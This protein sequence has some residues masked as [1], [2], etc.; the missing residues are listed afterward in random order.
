MVFRKLVFK[1]LQEIE[2]RLHN[3]GKAW[4]LSARE[5]LNQSSGP[6]GLARYSLNIKPRSFISHPFP[7][8]VCRSPSKLG[9]FPPIIHDQSAST[10]LTLFGDEELCP[11]W[12]K[13][14]TLVEWQAEEEIDFFDESV[15]NIEEGDDDEISGDAGKDEDEDV[16]D[17]DMELED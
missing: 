4:M 12:M 16:P 14:D 5:M 8:C 13:Q 6:D 2:E 17:D 3:P 15:L 1:S 11:E 10:R 9:V 7:E